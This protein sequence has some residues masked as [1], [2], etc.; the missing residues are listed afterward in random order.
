MKRSL[1]PLKPDKRK[2][3]GRKH[4]WSGRKD[5]RTS[6]DSSR[7][8]AA[9]QAADNATKEE[10]T[11]DNAV[12][13][14]EE[15]CTNYDAEE[16]NDADD[17]AETEEEDIN[18]DAANYRQR[19][20]E[21]CRFYGCCC[22]GISDSRIDM[23]LKETVDVRIEASDLRKLRSRMIEDLD[24]SVAELYKHNMLRDMD[25]YGLVKGYHHMC[26]SCVSQLCPAL[27][28]KSVRITKSSINKELF[29]TSDN[30]S[31]DDNGSVDREDAEKMEDESEYNGSVDSEETER[32]DDY[33]GSEHE[34]PKRK[35]KANVFM[36]GDEA[37][38]GIPKLALISG[39][40]LGGEIPIE[41]SRLN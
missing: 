32:M 40:Y 2:R 39:L 3:R 23:V 22:C 17:A 27:K 6:A 26:K 38:L 13:T 36:I 35:G 33:C 4:K 24:C 15:D 30:E 28:E 1:S 18:I 29:V 37:Y 31:D 9:K 5:P 20:E 21:T 19:L 41:L 11:A 8:R 12:E 10:D 7:S 34:T 16:E 25:E 14:I